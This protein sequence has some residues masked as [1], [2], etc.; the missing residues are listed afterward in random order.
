MQDVKLEYPT[1]IHLLDGFIMYPPSVARFEDELRKAAAEQFSRSAML[2]EVEL[3]EAAGAGRSSAAIR[4]QLEPPLAV[5][6]TLPSAVP[7]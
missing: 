6:Q 7:A 2:G 3:P 1:Y 4:V 5:V